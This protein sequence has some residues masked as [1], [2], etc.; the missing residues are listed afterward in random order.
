L[1]NIA[2]RIQ[3]VSVDEFIEGRSGLRDEAQSAGA[4][5]AS[6]YTNEHQPLLRNSRRPAMTTIHALAPSLDIEKEAAVRHGIGIL[7]WDQFA[8]TVVYHYL[9]PVNYGTGVVHRLL[10]MEALSTVD[11]STPGEHPFQAGD[12]GPADPHCYGLGSG[13]GHRRGLGKEQHFLH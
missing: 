5:K 10:K 6:N 13:R 12:R 9:F 7:R 4:H 2:R 11:D 3:V 8:F 1:A